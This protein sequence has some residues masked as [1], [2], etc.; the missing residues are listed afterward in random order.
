MICLIVALFTK[1]A[2]TENL[3]YAVCTV[4]SWSWVATAVV[5]SCYAKKE[6]S[7]AAKT[8]VAAGIIY[9]TIISIVY[10][11]QLT[12]VLYKSA[13]EKILQAFTFSAAG[14]WLFNLDLLGYGLLAVSTFF[15][16]LSLQAESRADKALKWLLTL[17]GIF[18]ICMLAPVLPL[19]AT[20]QGNGGTIALIGWCLFFLPVCV[21][22]AIHFKRSAALN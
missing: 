2:F 21:L 3:S 5:Y 8:G 11:T 17:H 6:R 22:S 13:D 15:T 14:S 9:S 7:A 10:Y 12:T 4:L 19:P 1:N 18:F 20:N 16:G